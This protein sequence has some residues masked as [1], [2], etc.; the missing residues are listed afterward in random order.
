[1]RRYTKAEIEDFDFYVNSN[2]VYRLW[3]D[4]LPSLT[5][6]DFHQVQG[7][8]HNK[9]E[10]IPLA[11][12]EAGS[13]KMNLINHLGFTVNIAQYGNDTYRIVGLEVEPLSIA[14]DEDRLHHDQKGVLAY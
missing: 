13:E 11:Y 4:G 12:R 6:S 9:Y 3:L 8:Q 5:V 2:Y 10:G 1:M 7:G 14:E